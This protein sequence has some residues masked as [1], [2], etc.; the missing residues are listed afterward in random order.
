MSAEPSSAA[1]QSSF[2]GSPH[3]VHKIT[4]ADGAIRI[5]RQNEHLKDDELW[6]G[7]G[8][9]AQTDEEVSVYIRI[10]RPAALMAELLFAT[11]ARAAGLPAA[12]PFV[13]NIPATAFP[14]N[15]DIT[16]RG[17]VAF[18]ALDAGG[19]AFSIM[20]N[21]GGDGAKLIRDWPALGA[22]AATDE[23]LLNSD[24]NLGNLVY[25]NKQITLIDH[26]EAFANRDAEL[27]TLAEFI[28]C[29]HMANK[30]LHFAKQQMPN[31]SIKA[32]WAKI[33]LWL[34]TDASR[35]DILSCI[36]MSEIQYVE[37]PHSPEE[38]AQFIRGRLTITGSLLCQKLWGQTSLALSNSHP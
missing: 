9:D 32:L 3:R 4:I 22:V 2:S 31:K 13:A 5:I 1:N 25:S 17:L 21:D 26:A 34:A 7:L 36:E 28:D 12:Q 11:I 29:G 27:W 30:L 6:H 35:L 24:R 8:Y 23:W 19:T 20:I 33:E 15:S 37:P 10:G 16:P 18:A 38:L 14:L